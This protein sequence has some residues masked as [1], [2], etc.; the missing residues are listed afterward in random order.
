MT[1]EERRDA[2]RDLGVALETVALHRARTRPNWR[3]SPRPRPFPCSRRPSAT[4]PTTCPARESLGYALGVLGR[5]QEAL[6]VCEQILRIRPGREW[7]LHSS[8]RVLIQD[9][10]GPIWPVGAA[11]DDRDQPMAS[12]Y[13]LALARVCSK[14]GDWPGAVAACRE[15]I[16]L[17]PESV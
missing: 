5:R 11:K 13:R 7:T 1:E 6:R 15:A 3:G 2:A 16:R 9:S 12:E 4:I 10:S 8:A 17:N 14:A